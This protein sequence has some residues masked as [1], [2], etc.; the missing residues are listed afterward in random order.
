MGGGL[1]T[2]GEERVNDLH[3][4]AGYVEEDLNDNVR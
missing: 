1:V 4:T 2:A 3:L